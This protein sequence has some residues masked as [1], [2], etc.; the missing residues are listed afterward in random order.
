MIKVTQKENAHI[1]A[2]ELQRKFSRKTY[3]PKKT[4]HHQM[5]MKSVPMRQ[6]EFYSWQ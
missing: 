2:K 4:Y 5:K 3:T 1:K 6:K